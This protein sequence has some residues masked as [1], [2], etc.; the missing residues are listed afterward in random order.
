M[1]P[2]FLSKI[3]SKKEKIYCQNCGAETLGG[4]LSK[5]KEIF[6]SQIQCIKDASRKNENLSIEYRTSDELQ[7]DIKSEKLIHFSKLEESV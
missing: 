1:L 6:C 2:Y 3:L 7:Q 5:D 4:Y